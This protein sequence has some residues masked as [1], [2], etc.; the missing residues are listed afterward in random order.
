MHIAA[1]LDVLFPQLAQQLCA[2]NDIFTRWQSVATATTA[3]AA[4]C[5]CGSGVCVFCFHI[6]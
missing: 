1:V 5:C 2:A 3:P 6:R 4:V